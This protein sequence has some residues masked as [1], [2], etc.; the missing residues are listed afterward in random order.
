M[1]CEVKG[2]HDLVVF[3]NFFAVCFDGVQHESKCRQ[4]PALWFVPCRVV[5]WHEINDVYLTFGVILHNNN[6]WF[7]FSFIHYIESVMHGG[8]AD[9]VLFSRFFLAYV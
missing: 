8:A 5:T 4:R 7:R 9:D 3:K 6:M 2:V 1:V